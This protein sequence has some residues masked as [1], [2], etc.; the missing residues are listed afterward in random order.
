MNNKETKEIEL[1]LDNCLS[2]KK[3]TKTKRKVKDVIEVCEE[4]LD[5]SFKYMSVYIEN[6]RLISNRTDKREKLQKELMMYVEGNDY[7]D[8]RIFEI[9]K[10]LGDA[11][12]YIERKKDQVDF[13]ENELDRIAENLLRNIKISKLLER[14]R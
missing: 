11:D 2:K 3:K 9:V 14:G 4:F 12:D 6:K 8:K 10:G 13:V 1:F 5:E 7:R